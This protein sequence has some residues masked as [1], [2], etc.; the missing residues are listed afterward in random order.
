MRPAGN[1]ELW[2]K[3]K[4]F[5]CSRA[6][7]RDGERMPYVAC[8]PAA[9]KI[10]V[11]RGRLMVLRLGD[12]EPKEILPADDGSYF[13]PQWSADASKLAVVRE[14]RVGPNNKAEFGW[15]DLK[16]PSFH[17]CSSAYASTS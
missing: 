8:A 9:D 17:S 6:W 11:G 5:E 10:G 14:I 7:S 13:V 4:V 16:D 3:G 2:T 12:A 15:I 1:G